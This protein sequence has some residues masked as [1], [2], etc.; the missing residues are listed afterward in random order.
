MEEREGV[1]VLRQ[2]VRE[3][4]RR[5]TV[6]VAVSA[7]ALALAAAA[8]ALA[9]R[10]GSNTPARFGVQGRILIADRVLTKE[11]HVVR[12]PDTLALDLQRPHMWSV[13]LTGLPGGSVAMRPGELY[14]IGGGV[15]QSAGIFPGYMMLID[16]PGQVM[17]LGPGAANMGV[18]LY[19]AGGR[20]WHFPDTAARPR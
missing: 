14:V 3:L 2:E 16:G 15:S 5:M 13:R 4:R 6:L 12:D 19:A 20:R 9:L 11:L 17:E 10:V 18:H 1:Q 7:I 8:V